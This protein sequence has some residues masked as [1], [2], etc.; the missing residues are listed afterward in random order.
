[1]AYSFSNYEGTTSGSTSSWGNGYSDTG[2]ADCTMT[3]HQDQVWYAWT[4]E[5]RTGDT[6]VIT[7]YKVV[8]DNVWKL[9]TKDYG[10]E[11]EG[12]RVTYIKG[13]STWKVAKKSVEQHRAEKAQKEINL[14]WSRLLV[15]EQEEAKRLAEVTAQELLEQLVSEED[16]AHYKEHGELLVRGR[17]KDYVIKKKGGVIRV[18]KDKIH[19]IERSVSSLCIH[20]NN[21]YK[22]PRSDNVIALKLAIDADE[23]KFNKEANASNMYSEVRMQEWRDK[24]D[25]LKRVA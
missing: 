10:Y 18:D 15:K 17:F 7:D 20:L 5:T 8:Q 13:M 11:C 6:L 16:F 12:G 14:I 2:T 21:Q 19:R 9:W 4:T 25:R 1:M 3:A 23:H 24:V 22:Y